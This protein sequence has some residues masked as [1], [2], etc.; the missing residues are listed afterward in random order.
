MLLSTW[1]QWLKENRGFVVFML[2]FGVYRTAVADWNPIPSG[3]MRPTILEGDVVFVDRLAYDVKLPLTD[4]SV[5]RL[6]EPQRGDVVTFSSPVDGTRLIKRLVAV[7]GDV[8]EV[9]HGV[10]L[11]NGVAAEYS[12]TTE[13]AEHVAEGVVLPAHRSTEHVAGSSRTVQFL[14]GVGAQRSFGPVTVPADHF[15][16]LGDNRDN[17]EDS[18]YIGFVPRHLL[19]GQ[20]NR[21]LVSAD[22]TDRWQPRFERMVS[23]IR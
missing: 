1:T 10:L 7:P 2:C 11:I 12:D 16:M 18:R 9:R 20:A 3:S 14:S 8:V 4:I 19:I 23:R 17:S 6:G 15:F 22:I 21:I 5:A 13:L